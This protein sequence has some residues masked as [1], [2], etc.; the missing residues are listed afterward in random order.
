MKKQSF[1]SKVGAFLAGRG[2][3]MVLVLCLAAIGGSGWFLWQEYRSAAAE[4]SAAAKVTVT[5]E[6]TT[7]ASD[8]LQ[9][10][11]GDTSKDAPQTDKKDTKE[12]TDKTNQTEKED[13][14]EKVD[15]AAQT[16]TEDAEATTAPAKT[17]E[18]TAAVSPSDEDKDTAAATAPESNTESTKPTSATATVTEEAATEPEG[19]VWPLKGE[20]V[21]AFSTDTLTYNEALGDW[22]THNGVDLSAGLGDDVVSACAGTVLTVEDDLLLGKTVT[23]DCGNNVTAIY[24]NLAEDCDVVA[25][26]KVAAGDL[27]G[28]VGATA[29][30]EDNGAAWLHFAVEKDGVAVDPMTYLN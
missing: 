15:T 11:T 27:L 13:K 19:W 21:A 14:A 12:Q 16:T 22:R 30:G 3:Y 8:A 20:V 2:F 26:D 7:S 10:E 4:A 28:V 29:L 18:E 25:G 1:W 9:V 23:V 17:E 24:G 5:E 6:E